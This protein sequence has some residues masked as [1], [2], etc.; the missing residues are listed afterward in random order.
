[1]L[2]EN[3]KGRKLSLFNGRSR[4]MSFLSWHSLQASGGLVTVSVWAKV[5]V[6]GIFLWAETSIHK[7]FG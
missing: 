7:M 5:S 2:V 6:D 4:M 3:R 1:M